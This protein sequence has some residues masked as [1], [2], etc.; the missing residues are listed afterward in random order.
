MATEIERKFLVTGVG[1][2]ALA[3][4]SSLLR[5]GY[6]SSNA[7]A[8]VRVRSWD[9][10][11][12]A[13]TLKGKASGIPVAVVRGLARLVSDLDTPGASTLVRSVEEDMFRFG[14]A[15][16]Y[17]LGYQAALAETG[18]ADEDR[19]QSIEQG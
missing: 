18:R 16:A 14:S 2:Q 3:E 8:T 19:L 7:K 1:W 9:D 12:A 5:Q 15:E 6:L 10:Q 4:G 13:L 11:R 17:R